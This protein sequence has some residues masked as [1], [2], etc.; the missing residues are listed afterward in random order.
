[1]PSH[2]AMRPS[3]AAAP[4]RAEAAGDAADA[5]TAS[6]SLSARQK[7]PRYFAVSERALA[8]RLAVA[9]RRQSAQLARVRGT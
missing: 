4:P 1:M 5:R 6:P 2:R 8:C 3:V 9:A 7:A